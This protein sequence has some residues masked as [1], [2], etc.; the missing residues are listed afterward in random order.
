MTTV[1]PL[2]QNVAA[3]QGTSEQR[4]RYGDS[5]P[6]PVIARDP[7]G[8]VLLGELGAAR[9]GRMWFVESAGDKVR[10]GYDSAPLVKRLRQL[11]PFSE[12]EVMT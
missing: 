3:D 9:V 10:P 12:Y 7:R 2:E 4:L 8:W 5:K 11:D 1:N 6:S